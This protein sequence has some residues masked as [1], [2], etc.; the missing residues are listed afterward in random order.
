MLRETP[1][2][3]LAPMR[4]GGALSAILAGC[5]APVV[6]VAG[7]SGKT[8][9]AALIADMLYEAGHGV[10]LGLAEALAHCGSLTETD[11]VV[12]E[13]SSALAATAPPGLALLALTGLAA[14]ELGPSQVPA[15]VAAALGQALAGARQIVVNADD[16]RCLA[17]AAMARAPVRRAAARNRVADATVRDG[18][19]VAVDPVSGVERRV[20]RL[21]D[22]VL[23]S[24]ALVADILV[25]TAAA[26]ALGARIDDVRVAV[27]H[28]A[29]G[30]DR[31]ELVAVRGRV[32]WVCDAAATRPGRTVAALAACD[33]PVH[34]VAGG[35][36]GG[37][38][39]E[40]WAPAA[41]RVAASVLL[42]GPA[43]APLADA[44][45]RVGGG[46]AIVRCAD[47]D[48]ATLAAGQLA[49][50]GDTVLFSPGCEPESP[51]PPAVGERFRDL[52]RSPRARRRAAA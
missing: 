14:D 13:M 9:T 48:D 45:V 51:G 22:R 15:D 4:P 35:R 52:V 19:L 40:R 25:A 12:I 34:L 46:A 42:F 49:R 20:C 27:L 5:R 24:P 30:P 36:F 17:L 18:E 16:A 28:F 50:A 33:G 3:S 11:R 2:Q 38:S 29:P 7:A 43:G 37:Q 31:H 10:T 23:A 8:T 26:L 1:T 39:L 44:L 41:R 32:R 21:P 6:A 47:L